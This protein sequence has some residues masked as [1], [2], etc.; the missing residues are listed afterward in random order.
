MKNLKNNKGIT[1]I[2]LIIMVI[3]IQ[4]NDTWIMLNRKSIKIT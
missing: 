2:I 4:L 1:I 3:Q